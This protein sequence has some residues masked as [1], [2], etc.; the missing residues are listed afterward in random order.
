M[1]RIKKTNIFVIIIGCQYYAILFFF[2]NSL[3]QQFLYGSFEPHLHF[4]FLGY[5]GKG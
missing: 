3:K 5:P 4:L 1:F 2:W